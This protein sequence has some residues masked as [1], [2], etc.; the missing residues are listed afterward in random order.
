MRIP[1]PVCVMGKKWVI[2][3]INQ[4]ELAL[5]DFV[6]YSHSDHF[7]ERIYFRDNLQKKCHFATRTNPTNPTISLP[8]AARYLRP[9]GKHAYAA[10][11]YL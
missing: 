8:I 10:L 4:S 1:C 9:R 5:L 2:I 7:W 3:L 11:S 6:Y